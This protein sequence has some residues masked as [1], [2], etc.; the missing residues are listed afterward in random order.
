MRSSH[1]AAGL[2]PSGKRP[3]WLPSEVAIELHDGLAAILEHGQRFAGRRVATILSGGNIDLSVISSV[4]LRE[5]VRSGQL[6]RVAVSLP[7][8]PG[9]LAK[10]TAIVGDAGA[11]IVE[12]AHE[13]PSLSLNAKGAALE[14]IVHVESKPHGA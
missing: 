6:I 3:F 14:L 2:G 4:A 8:Q 1:Q 13:R 7:D 12:I 10:L 11:N 9:A 5:L